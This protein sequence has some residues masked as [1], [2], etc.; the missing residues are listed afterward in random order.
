MDPD[1]SKLMDDL[2]EAGLSKAVIDAAWPA[3]WSD[4]V[5]ASPSSRAELRFALA[6]RLGLAPKA[7]LGERVEFVWKDTARFK[8]LSTQDAHQQNILNS[9]G[10]SVGRLVLNATE[11]GPGLAGIDAA[12]LRDIILKDRQFVDLTSL[13]GTCWGLGVPVVHLRVFPLSTKSMHAMVVEADGR[14]AILIGRDASYPA[15]IAFTLAHEIGHIAQRHL[16]GVSAL[17]DVEDPAQAHDLD[18]EEIEADA[19]GLTILT[20][21]D[22]PDIRTNLD[23]FNA[24]TLAKAVLEAGARYR[25][26]PGTLA[27]SLA[28]RRNNWPVAISSLGFV[29]DGPADIG[30]AVNSIADRS[31]DWSGIGA[32]SAEYLRN[33]MQLDDA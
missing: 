29:Y 12:T 18:R 27:L 7:L 25:I 21:S 3:W 1:S 20:G 30:K 2:R 5:A 17:I 24:P 26:E 23:D 8:H 15:Q 22:D 32:D 10:V 13:L 33:L 31:L 19:F 14:H 4:E 16:E 11:P 9:F 6:R 28:Y